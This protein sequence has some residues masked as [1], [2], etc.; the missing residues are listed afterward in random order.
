MSF[1]DSSILIESLVAGQP[2]HRR[3]AEL[4]DEATDTATH[5]L[6]ET[7]SQLTGGRLGFRVAPAEA[8]RLIRQRTSGLRPISLSGAQMLALLDDTPRRG[9]RGGA[10]YD[11]L[12]LEAARLADAEVVWTL[13]LSDFRALAPDLDVRSPDAG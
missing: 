3:C 6:A 13:N 7:F 8:A 1:V 5:C 12:I 10:I 4:V 2:H 11:L 9:A